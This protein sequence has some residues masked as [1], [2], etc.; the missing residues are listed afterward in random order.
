MSQKA[1]LV[2]E[3]R[4]SKT[5]FYVCVRLRDKHGGDP[6]LIERIAVSGGPHRAHAADAIGALAGAIEKYGPTHKC[7]LEPAEFE[8]HRE[9]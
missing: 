6:W 2:T 3:L 8:T 5:Q 9:E 4:Q 1:T 7:V